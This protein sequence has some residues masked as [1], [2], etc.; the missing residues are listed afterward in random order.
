MTVT[1]TIFPIQTDDHLV[2]ASILSAAT[3]VV[4]RLREHGHTAFFAGGFARDLMIG[5]PVHDIDIATDAPPDTVE[6][7]FPDSRSFGKSFGVVQVTMDSHPFEVATFRTEGP[8]VDG[9]R[10]ESVCFTT[11]DQDASRR[12]FTVNGMFYDPARSVIVDYV[13]GLPDLRDK[14]IR[15]IGSPEER[16][17]ED[18]LRLMR[19]VRFASVLEFQIEP[20]T[21]QAIQNSAHLL[22]RI[23]IERI[24]DEFMR[25]LMESPHPGR[26]LECLRDAGILAVILPE[27]QAMN[28][29]EQPPEFHP[30]GDVFR[31]VCLMLENMRER[32][33]ELIWSILMHDVAKPPTF[34]IGTDKAGNPRIRFFG[35]AEKGAEMAVEIMQRFR[36]PNDLINAVEIAVRHHMRFSAVPDMRN[37]T[38]RKWVGAPTFP[39]ELELH[40]IDCISCHGSLDHYEQIKTFRDTLANEPAL[41]KPLI[42]GRDLI[43][44]NISTGPLMGVILK[45]LYDQQ[46]E[47]AFGDPTS[48]HAWLDEHL[49][50]VVARLSADIQS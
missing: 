29:V 40:R 19:A 12:D 21:W 24:R 32:S 17:T 15:A 38:L 10:P 41:P 50:S 13:N 7:L 49:S 8:Y 42:T 20:Q 48:A 4:T 2:P 35:H 36:C 33:P 14:I 6:E 37:A 39:L 34:S 5:R 44:R 45:H 18:H 25:T 22:V 23:S 30:E 28:G 31:H 47:G 46:L 43:D 3:A 27:I 16:F 11:A 9:R 1:P 26:A